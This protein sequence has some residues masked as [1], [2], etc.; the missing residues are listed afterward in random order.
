MPAAAR[1]GDMSAGH[2]YYPRPNCQ[3]SPNVFINGLAAHRIGDR[4]PLHTCNSSSHDGVLAQGSPN[5]FING[6][7]LGRIGD[8]I[9][10][11]DIV[12]QGSPNVFING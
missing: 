5:V 2:C 9:S 6:M 1:F 11:G 3:G 12:A 4:W 10:C 7:A 8:M